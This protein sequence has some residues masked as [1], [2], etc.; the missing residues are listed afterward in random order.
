MPLQVI[1]RAATLAPETPLGRALTDAAYLGFFFMLRAGEYLDTTSP[2]DRPVRLYQVSFKT[3]DGP[4]LRADTS[5]VSALETCEYASITFEIQKNGHKG[6][7]AVHYMS[8]HAHCCPV[9]ALLRRVLYLRSNGGHAETPITA[10]STPDGWALP[11]SCDLTALLRSAADHTPAV[12]YAP[13]DVSPRSLRSGGA[14]SLLLAGVD[15]KTIKLVG[16]WR[17]DAFF[18]YMHSMA[19]PLVRTH[20]KRMLDHGEFT[21]M[22]GN[23]TKTQASAVLDAEFIHDDDID[24]QPLLETEAPMAAE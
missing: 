19:L 8:G 16:R 14:M 5:P 11:R 23:L 12:D 13:D 6:H 7:A 15:E 18:S 10:V 17:S 4:T 1:Q 20:S 24:D 2:E 9:K 21:L 22:S 3:T